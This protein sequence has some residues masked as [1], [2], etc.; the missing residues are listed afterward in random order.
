MGIFY[1]F[2]MILSEKMIKCNPL[3]NSIITKVYY[4]VQALKK[5]RHLILSII[6]CFLLYNNVLAPH[7]HV[8]QKKNNLIVTVRLTRDLFVIVFMLRSLLS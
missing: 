2:F 7:I 4:V 1:R 3:F 8:V 5:N 6:C